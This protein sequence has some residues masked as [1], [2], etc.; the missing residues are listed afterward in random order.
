MLGS[1]EL[2]VIAGVV[3]LLFG[4]TAI[5]RIARS[6]GRA[7]REFEKGLEEGRR[8]DAE[9]PEA[10]DGKSNRDRGPAGDPGDSP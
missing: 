9:P 5:P 1:T 10:K 6:L 8:D 2:L 3:L 7:R 4:A